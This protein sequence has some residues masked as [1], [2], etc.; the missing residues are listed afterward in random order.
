MPTNRC[1]A[2]SLA[3]PVACCQAQ[4]AWRSS[5]NRGRPFLDLGAFCHR[6]TGDTLPVAPDDE[7]EWI[8]QAPFQ[9]RLLLVGETTQVPLTFTPPTTP[10]SPTPTFSLGGREPTRAPHPRL[11][12]IDVPG[13]HGARSRGHGDLRRSESFGL[14]LADG[15]L[16]EGLVAEAADVAF[17]GELGDLRGF[18]CLCVP[19]KAGTATTSKSLPGCGC[20]NRF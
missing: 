5:Q 8:F 13:I 14:H 17:V 15:L 19:L 20:Q 7:E 9:K 18:L 12:N 6:K 1:Q 4:Y 3:T 2:V 11:G 10:P 16:L